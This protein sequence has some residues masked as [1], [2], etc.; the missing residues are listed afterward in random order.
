MCLCL[1]SI[2]SLHSLKIILLLYRLE[3]NFVCTSIVL[4]VLE[5]GS[6]AEKI[7]LA[8]QVSA[9]HLNIGT[10]LR[11]DAIMNQKSEQK[12]IEYLKSLH[13][14]YFSKSKKV[15]VAFEQRNVRRELKRQ[16]LKEHRLKSERFGSELTYLGELSQDKSRIAR[17]KLQISLANPSRGVP[18]DGILESPARQIDELEHIAST[19]GS[20]KMPS[21]GT[22]TGA[23][24]QLDE[25]KKEL[26]LLKL[27]CNESTDCKNFTMPDSSKHE[28]RLLSELDMPK[29]PRHELRDLCR[30]SIIANVSEKSKKTIHN[31]DMSVALNDKTF[32]TASDDKQPRFGGCYLGNIPSSFDDSS[33]RGLDR[34]RDEFSFTFKEMDA[35]PRTSV[36]E[37]TRTSLPHDSSEVSVFNSKADIVSGSELL[38]LKPYTIETKDISNLFEVDFDDADVDVK[39]TYDRENS[40]L[41]RMLR[42][43][44]LS[45]LE[46]SKFR[47]DLYSTH[48]ASHGKT[49]A[50]DEAKT[51][52]PSFSSTKDKRERLYGS[53]DASLS[54]KP[55]YKEEKVSVRDSTSTEA[56][57]KD[58]SEEPRQLQ[59]SPSKERRF[60][61]QVLAKKSARSVEPSPST[62][63]HL[64][65]LTA[66]I[67]MSAKNAG[68]MF[69]EEAP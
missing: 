55:M 12:F 39:K 5:F 17:E 1:I 11:A 40:A 15:Y 33:R 35:L 69:G 19:N 51:M 36:H 67:R 31:G 37:G 47:R 9:E 60:R 26:E 25:L 58:S 46:G 56:L 64:H 49:G 29:N 18:S 44:D 13:Q 61:E 3:G 32:E 38:H 7:S 14:V 63:T 22:I 66:L 54:R 28:S 68:A 21:D 52:S 50:H 23:K 30:G 42:A 45:R 10:G 2:T 62:K 34:S 43:G 48:S 65:A 53:L 6:A 16:Q 27:E 24:R 20:T 4:Q 57:A 41:K 59:R 8:L